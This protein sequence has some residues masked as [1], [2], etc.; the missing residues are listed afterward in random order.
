MAQA[1]ELVNLT[2]NTIPAG[3]VLAKVTDAL[4][5]SLHLDEKIAVREAAFLTPKS[6]DFVFFRRFSDGRSSQVAAYVVDNT[7]GSF[8][9]TDLFELH[10]NIW[11][12][13]QAPLLYVQEQG[14]VDIYSCAGPASVIKDNNWRPRPVDVV[15]ISSDIAEAIKAK[16]FSA[17]RLVDGTFWED[18]RNAHLVNPS[19][20]AHRQLIAEVEH[21]DKVLGGE[22]NPAARH[23]LL[24][25]LLLKYLEDRGVFP[26][27]WFSAFHPDSPS[28]LHVF[29]HG[30]K[31]AS[32]KMFQA[33]GAKFNG[34]IFQLSKEHIDI[35]D[36]ELLRKLTDLICKDLD[37]KTG[38]FYL[39]EF[40]SFKH[41]PVEVLSHIYQKFADRGKGAVFTPPM[42]VNLIL[43]Q[44]MPLSSLRGNET[45][46][47]PSCGSG[48][49][50]VSAFRRLVHAWSN[51]RDWKRP[52]PRELSELL[53]RTIFGIELQPQAS[54]LASFSLAL[55]VCDALQ[56]NVI[57]EQLR[58]D[59]LLGANILTGD[60]CDCIET[61]KSKTKD[62][63][64]FDLIIGNP[65]FMSTLTP[66]MIKRSNYTVPDNQAAYFFLIDCATTA[67][68]QSGK[69][70]ML[71]NAG[72]LYN[73]KVNTFRKEFFSSITVDGILD[74][75]SIRG[76]FKGA[77]TKVVAVLA[78]NSPPSLSHSI[79]HWTF[80]RTF[81]ADRSIHFDLDYYDYH[82]VNQSVAITKNYLPWRT[83]LLGGGRLFN[84]ASKLSSLPT[85][86]DKARAS[87]WRI[88]EGYI[89]GNKKNH[90]LWLTN[91]PLLTSQ[92]L[93]DG[94][95]TICPEQLSRV[96]DE[97]FE[98]PRAVQLFTPP[99]F[100]IREHTSLPCAFWDKESLA[101]T[102]ET[103]GIAC[104]DVQKDD[105]KC[106]AKQ[107][108]DMRNNLSAYIQLSG[109][110]SL[111]TR[112]TPVYKKDIAMLPCPTDKGWEL[113][114]WESEM[115]E[116]VNNY[117]ADYVRLGQDSALLK[118]I[119][120]G[121]A[122]LYSSTF[123][124]LLQKVFP[125][126]EHVGCE[127]EDGLMYQAF[128]FKKSSI[129][130][131]LTKDWAQYLR[132]VIFSTQG[133]A[134]SFC[135]T[136]ILR[137]YEGDALILIKPDRLRYWIRSI[138]IRDVDDVLHDMM[139]GDEQNA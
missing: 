36:D 45:V 85:I 96:S 101:Y 87:G 32:L 91:K 1:L 14:R 122:Q 80:R 75:V 130:P 78:T 27:N 110:R 28:C 7:T 69:I 89:V 37:S 4:D 84:I 19:K 47:D 24:L 6:P 106:F 25:T 117:M 39:W 94:A 31:Q 30:G 67:L 136:R 68:R 15:K 86:E 83:N 77:D 72:F 103:V 40:Y 22:K 38:Q 134:E 120:N 61:V 121:E 16:R 29:K 108:V 132:S 65:P 98:A 135:S 3:S 126:A 34:D 131:W 111:T 56:P 107:F 116:D 128:S 100:V 97:Y 137:V 64:G 70:C 133:D 52:A 49:F 66:S 105:L 41:I 13:G 50:L 63:K 26:Q 23:L 95:T 119:Q 57:W 55:A 102:N 90:A 73:E 42:V 71:Q 115:L 53:S 125:S 18:E 112:A 74:F 104:N 114:S 60:Y 44:V 123:L 11:L 138:A 79:Q 82:R 8:S 54:E 109:S 127:L 35:I 93:P 21:A 2:A 76:L 58:F 12:S 81:A 33:L 10:R 129:I 48:I 113:A 17:F 5:D 99:L 139:A 59:K 88:G 20:A 43:D 51:S 62:G 118:K 92:A 9:S 46:L 124:R